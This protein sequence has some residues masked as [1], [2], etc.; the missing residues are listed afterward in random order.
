M[1][2]TRTIV[3]S[4][5]TTVGI[6]FISK[7]HSVVIC[8]LQGQYG[9]PAKLVINVLFDNIKRVASDDDDDGNGI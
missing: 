7:V 1:Y 5:I 4:N 6:Q 8:T 9:L 3:V 2:C